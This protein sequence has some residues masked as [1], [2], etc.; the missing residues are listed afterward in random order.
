MCGGQCGEDT[1]ARTRSLAAAKQ[2]INVPLAEQ[3]VVPV[4]PLHAEAPK[5]RKMLTELSQFL[6]TLKATA[7]QLTGGQRW[8]RI[9]SRV[10]RPLLGEVELEMPAWV[11]APD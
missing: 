8:C 10:F 3:P 11:G 5:I 2:T 1:W 6:A 4:T 7:Q 9:L